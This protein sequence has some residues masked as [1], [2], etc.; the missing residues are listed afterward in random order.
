LQIKQKTNS[1]KKNHRKKSECTGRKKEDE[2]SS[3]TGKETWL[4]NPIP[5]REPAAI[6]W[7][8]G[9]FSQNYFSEVTPRS[10]DSISSKTISVSSAVIVVWA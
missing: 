9:A 2:Q 1:N 8:C 5:S 3:P 6:T 10:A 4:R 7:Y